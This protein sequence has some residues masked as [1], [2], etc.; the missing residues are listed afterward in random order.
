MRSCD[1]Q[2]EQRPAFVQDRS[3][4]QVHILDRK[5][6]NFLACRIARARRDETSTR[7]RADLDRLPKEQ[8]PRKLSGTRTA[9]RSTLWKAERQLPPMVNAWPLPRSRR[10]SQPAKVAP[11]A[12]S[13][14]S[15]LGGLR[16]DVPIARH[17]APSGS[18]YPSHPHR[19]VHPVVCGDDARTASTLR[20]VRSSASQRIPR[21]VLDVIRCWP[22]ASRSRA[23]SQTSAGRS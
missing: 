19:P 20:R 5:L 21:S 10:S 1:L 11:H 4:A 13:V 17:A 9:R 15:N 7:G 8:P 2:A 22:P 3:R 6:T 14:R 23:V 16:D 18:T 12:C